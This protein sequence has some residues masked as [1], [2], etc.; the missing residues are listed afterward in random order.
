M[1]R[2][3]NELENIDL[4]RDIDT[5]KYTKVNVDFSASNAQIARKI[6]QDEIQKGNR[7]T[8]DRPVI[9]EVDW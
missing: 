8:V 4:T 3:I 6:E 9:G 2:R 5:S 7:M 1:A